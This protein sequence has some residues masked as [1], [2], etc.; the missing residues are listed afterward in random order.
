ML[1]TKRSIRTFHNS[2][3]IILRHS[4]NKF[5][6]YSLWA[7]QVWV[8]L[9]TSVF[10]PLPTSLPI[11]SPSQSCSSS[12]S[13]P[14]QHHKFNT[15]KLPQNNT[16]PSNLSSSLL[17]ISPSCCSQRSLSFCNFGMLQSPSAS[18]FNPRSTCTS[19]LV[20]TQLP[21]GKLPSSISQITYSS[22][23]TKTTRETIIRR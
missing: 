12:S 2:I 7:F 1:S 18:Q 10:P 23:S 6:Y 8:W 17:F 13:L 20:T 11:L 14:Q 4:F 22:G 19:Q 5:T 16:S 9:S 3:A 21:I 15:S